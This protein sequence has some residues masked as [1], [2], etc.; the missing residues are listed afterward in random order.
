MIELRAGKPADALGPLAKARKVREELYNRQPDNPNFA[1][2]LGR[3]LNDYGMALAAMGR[4]QDAV[5]LFRTA[6]GH[7]LKALK[8]A[9]RS[10]Q[11]QQYLSNHYWNLSQSLRALARPAEAAAA[12]RD[13]LAIRSGD[14]GFTYD[15]ACELAHCVKLVGRD[16]SDARVERDRYARWAIDAL[17]RAVTAGFRDF[18]HMKVDADLDPLRRRDDFQL[19]MMDLTFPRVPFVTGP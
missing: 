10:P 11:F 12:A 5:E 15:M 13:A 2:G 1:S 4:H 14:P 8:S 6:V 3:I 9:P 16:D 17:R 18:A 7:Q 19:L